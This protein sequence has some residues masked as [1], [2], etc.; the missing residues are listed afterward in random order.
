MT[1]LFY[2]YFVQIDFLCDLKFFH[3][4]QIDYARTASACTCIKNAKNRRGILK[5][6]KKI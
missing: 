5:S 1:C 2:M 6:K 3:D 4:N